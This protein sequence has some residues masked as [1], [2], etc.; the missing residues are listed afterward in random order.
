M[1]R[2]WPKNS[3]FTRLSN[4]TVVENLY[5]VLGNPQMDFGCIWHGS[6]PPAP[7]LAPL[8]RIMLV[9]GRAEYRR[10]PSGAHEMCVPTGLAGEM[11]VPKT[12]SCLFVLLLDPARS[13]PAARLRHS[14]ST[15]GPEH[16]LSRTWLLHGRGTAPKKTVVHRP[17]LVV[18]VVKC[19]QVPD[20]NPALRAGN[21]NAMILRVSIAHQRRSFGA[22][23]D[24]F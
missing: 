18:V 16:C 9:R 23:F 1:P 17:F 19:C 20:P 5:V 11:C 6:S 2:K 3:I 14:R 7:P 13:S 21:K 10:S 8:A 12:F 4:F 22:N 24:W 15:L